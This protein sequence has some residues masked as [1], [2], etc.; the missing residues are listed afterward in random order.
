[1]NLQILTSF[2]KWIV[3]LG[4]HIVDSKSFQIPEH[5]DQSWHMQ[6]GQYFNSPQISRKLFNQTEYIV[7]G[8]ETKMDRSTL[9]WHGNRTFRMHRQVLYHK[10]VLTP[11]KCFVWETM[12]SDKSQQHLKAS[13]YIVAQGRRVI[14]CRCR[15]DLN[16]TIRE[17]RQVRLKI[18]TFGWVSDKL[19]FYFKCCMSNKK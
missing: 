10:N 19:Y 13:E 16:D 7:N 8:F 6:Q 4:M 9:D 14:N 12:S 5:D 17:N 18:C 3:R 11:L 1:M 2:S 15:L